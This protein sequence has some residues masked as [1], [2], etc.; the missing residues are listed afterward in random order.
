MTNAINSEPQRFDEYMVKYVDL[1]HQIHSSK[2]E[3]NQMQDIKD[4]YRG[5][6][7]NLSEYLTTDEKSKLIE[8]LDAIP[9]ENSIVHGDFHCKNIMII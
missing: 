6:I 7:D 5:Y 2:D 3:T 8:V 9:D 1:L 4:I